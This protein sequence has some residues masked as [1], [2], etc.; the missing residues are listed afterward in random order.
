MRIW[1]IKIVIV[2]VLHSTVVASVPV[3]YLWQLDTCNVTFLPLFGGFP[4][5]FQVVLKQLHKMSM[6]T[7][8][9]ALMSSTSLLPD[10]AVF[11]FL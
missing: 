2:L 9:T 7:P 10:L 6:A 4:L 11:P 5:F 8:L 1:C 3:I